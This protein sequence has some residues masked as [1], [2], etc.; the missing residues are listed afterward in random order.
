MEFTQ[1]KSI[2]DLVKNFDTEQKCIDYLQQLRWV[3]GI[4]SPF[5][6]DSK[7]YVC[8]GNKF[9]CKNT[10]KYFNVR[11]GTMFDDTKMPLQKWFMGIYIVASHKKGISSHQLAR[12]LGITQKS[13]WFMLHRIRYTFGH[14]NFNEEMGNTVEID[15]TFIGGKRSNMHS[16]KRKELKQMGGGYM[17]MTPVF[18]MLE[19]GGNV[20]AMK[21]S[22]ANRNV[23]KPIILNNISK[24]AIIVSD[25]FGA[26]SD[27]KHSFKK[28]KVVS[29]S[30]GQYVKGEFHTNSIEGFWSLLKRGIVGIYHFV[31]PK[32]LDHYVTEFAYRY[33][34]R[35]LTDSHRFALVLT[36]SN[37]KIKY[38]QL[39]N[40]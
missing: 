32:H 10:G 15:E 18:G 21:V 26:Y 6:I 17:N 38:N 22:D 34:T 11:T 8:A 29:H 5:D 4:V 35:T 39:I 33:N 3:D 24:E 2:I 30:T 16:F 14:D 13:A 19:R 20:K 31:S 9:K 40:K 12:D 27:L 36:N 1:F 37:N 28:H 7:V 23:L 25:S